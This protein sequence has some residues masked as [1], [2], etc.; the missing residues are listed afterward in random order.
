[1]TSSNCLFSLTDTPKPKDIQFV[2]KHRKAASDLHIQRLES[3]NVGY[4]YLLRALN[5]SSIII[6]VFLISAQDQL[7]VLQYSQVFH[8][9][10]GSVTAH[11]FEFIVSLQQKFV[12]LTFVQSKQWVETCPK[13]LSKVL[14]E[15]GRKKSST[16]A[17]HS[18]AAIYNTI[19]STFT[20]E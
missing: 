20:F 14:H 16:A 7:F 12:R 3:A 15:T 13:M 2:M 11:S 10:S 6:K 5:N 8:E 19:G 17:L 4:F 9:V 18:S 1:M